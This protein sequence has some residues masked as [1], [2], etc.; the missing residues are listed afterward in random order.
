M[1]IVFCANNAGNDIVINRLKDEHP[2][3]EISMKK[4]L[5][6]CGACATASIAMINDKLYVEESEDELY[7]QIEK[8]L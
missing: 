5:N 3:V 8:K 4:C 7:E 2:E 6:K 1:K